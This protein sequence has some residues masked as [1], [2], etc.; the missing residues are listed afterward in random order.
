[1]HAPR[2]LVLMLAGSATCMLLGC[3]KPQSEELPSTAAN[4]EKVVNLF[5]WADYIGPE[6]VSSFSKDTGIKV[7]ISYVESN[8][9]VESRVLTGHS[10]FDLVVTPGPYF[11]RQIRSGAYLVLDKTQL[12]NSKNLDPALMSQSALNDPGNA[13][14]V[15]YTWGTYGIGYNPKPVAALLPDVP[16]DSWRLIFDPAFASKLSK[17]GINILDTPPAVVRLILKYLGRNA[18]APTAPD[19]SDVEATLRKIRPYVRTIDSSGYIQALA[20]G[21]ICIALGT[22][23]DLVQA[24]KQARDSK[25]GINM[26][27]IIPKEGS[28]LWIDNLAIPKDAPHVANAYL[29]LNYLMNPNAIAQTSNAIG[30]AN[31]NAAATPLL[32]SAIATDPIIYPTVQDRQRLFVQTE[33]PPEQA[34][35]ITRLWQKFK[36]GQ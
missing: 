6:T 30:F 35:A 17:C 5:N 29:L 9:T 28:I 19:L 33:D 11:Q 23:G 34:R 24:R 16:V 12:P 1:M 13:H 32:D 2:F 14:G 36:T 31:G 25:N 3:G 7:R 27:Y 26:S 21:E 8:E 18:N 4:D 10:G 15:V 22:N 20:N